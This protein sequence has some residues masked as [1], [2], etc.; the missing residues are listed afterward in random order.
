MA[1]VNRTDN[2]SL[3]RLLNRFNKVLKGSSILNRYKEKQH[4]LRKPSSRQKKL[5]ALHR[6]KMQKLAEKESYR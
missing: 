1:Y 5:S 6:V 3:D 2:E 4:F